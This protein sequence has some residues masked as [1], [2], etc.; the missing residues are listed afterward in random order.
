MR[1]SLRFRVTV[2]DVT[3][4]AIPIFEPRVFQ[5]LCFLLKVESGFR[6]KFEFEFE[7]EFESAEGKRTSKRLPTV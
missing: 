5:S 4:I 7:F 1:R 6:F 2:E 3:L